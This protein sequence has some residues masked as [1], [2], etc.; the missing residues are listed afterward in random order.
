MLS[1]LLPNFVGE[2]KTTSYL[3]WPCYTLFFYSIRL[4]QKL[5]KRSDLLH[6]TRLQS[7]EPGWNNNAAGFAA[8]LFSM[9]QTRGALMGPVRSSLQFRAPLCPHESVL[10]EGRGFTTRSVP[11]QRGTLCELETWP[12]LWAAVQTATP[13][14][15][16]PSGR[17]STVGK[18][19]KKGAKRISGGAGPWEHFVHHLP[20]A[21]EEGWEA[22]R[23][24]LDPE[25]KSKGGVR[26]SSL[27]SLYYSSIIQ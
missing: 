7:R 27:K 12:R 25:R 2:K 22:S 1:L 5:L 4:K 21:G 11:N 18:M 9:T 24:A 17:H 26:K 10:S 15:T 13:M 19:H 16:N 6:W 20:S 8:V 14:M 3:L 23:T